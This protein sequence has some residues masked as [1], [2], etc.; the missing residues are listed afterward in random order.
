MNKK[1]Q[2]K[3]YVSSS[4]VKILKNTHE[5]KNKEETILV[6]RKTS[7]IFCGCPCLIL[8]KT[9]KDKLNYYY[10]NGLQ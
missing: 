5:Y 6:K 10:S 8:Q 9:R 2:R 3:S 1:V 4:R 7:E